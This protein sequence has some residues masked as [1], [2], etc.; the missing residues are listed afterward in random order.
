MLINYQRVSSMPHS[1]CSEPQLQDCQ[2]VLATT[3]LIYLLFT[4]PSLRGLTTSNNLWYTCCQADDTSSMTLKGYKRT[5]ANTN[6]PTHTDPYAASYT[7]LTYILIYSNTF[8]I[9]M[10]IMHTHTCCIHHS[11]SRQTSH[12]YLV[13]F[14][15]LKHAAC[16]LSLRRWVHLRDELLNHLVEVAFKNGIVQGIPVT[17]DEKKA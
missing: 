15:G 8:R 4:S 11:N 12:L 14:F 5:H 17:W 6:K 16:S 3:L 7:M 10:H 1:R 9:Y 2:I 13:T